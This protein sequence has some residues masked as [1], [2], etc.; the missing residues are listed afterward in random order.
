MTV[1][2]TINANTTIA[3]LSAT[4]WLSEMRKSR[5]NSNCMKVASA[6]G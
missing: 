4:D 2:I 3:R 5:V 6:S 1:A